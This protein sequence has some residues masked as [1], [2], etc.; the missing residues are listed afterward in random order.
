MTMQRDE[1]VKVLTALMEP[2]RFD[3]DALS[4]EEAAA[5]RLAIE[6]IDVPRWRPMKTVL[7]A[8][9]NVMALG[10]TRRIGPVLTT[11][12]ALQDEPERFCGWFPMPCAPKESP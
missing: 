10:R 12:C 5:I 2:D 1:A 11:T 6:A 7:S 3:V 4:A 8:E 9:R